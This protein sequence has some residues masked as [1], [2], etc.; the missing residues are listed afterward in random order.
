[1]TLPLELSRVRQDLEARS[2]SQWF[3]EMCRLQV[4]VAQTVT[5][6]FMLTVTAGAFLVE[7]LIR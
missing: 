1:M 2:R 3:T 4:A 7:A 6:I 5:L